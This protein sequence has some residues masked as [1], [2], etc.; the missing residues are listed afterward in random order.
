MWLVGWI[1]KKGAPPGRS[2]LHVLLLLF[3][4][5]KIISALFAADQVVAWVHVERVSKIILFYYVT[6]SLVDTRARFRLMVLVVAVS[7][8]YL[9]FWGNWQWYVEGVGG[10]PTGELA[11][12]GWEVNASFADRNV[13][14]YMLAIGIPFAFFVFLVERA[15][16]I[17]WPM[18]ACLPLLMN[19]VMLT[20]GRAAFIAMGVGATWSVLR[21][22]RVALI[23]GCGV[24]GAILIYRLAGSDVVSRVLTI[25]DYEQDTS[26]TGRLEAWKAGFQMMQDHPLVG[27][28]PDNFGRYSS[29][30]NPRVREGLV[31]HNEFIQTAAESGILA[32]LI[33]LAILAVAFHNL[34]RVRRA[35]SPAGKTKWAYYYAAM[36]ESSLVC[37]VIS[38]MFVS[39]PYFELFF[40][41]LGLT[42]CLRRIVERHTV[43]IATIA[44]EPRDPPGEARWQ[45]VPASP[46]IR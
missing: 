32:G 1:Q 35:T 36:I 27:V 15:A 42:L 44:A 22:R 17:R 33:L 45:A 13:F 40:L 16:W 19:A 4:L 30:Y 39:L 5:V 28:G 8:A 25:P 11:G 18:L 31:A 10:G 38:A 14:A 7:L 21:L 12:P 26:A 43:K 24:L 6:V 23:V 29:L 9:G 41:L 3:L 2:P 46:G 34:Y 37:Y 20:F